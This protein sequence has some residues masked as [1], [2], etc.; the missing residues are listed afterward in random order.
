V[1][2]AEGIPIEGMYVDRNGDGEVT[3]EDR[4][5]YKDAN[6]EFYFGISS[7]LSYKNWELFFSGRANFGNYMYNNVSSENGVYQRLYRAEGPYLSNVT[8][9]VT[10][11]GFVAPQ[12]L[13]D[14]FIQ[15][16][17]FFKMDVI[18]LSY[19]LEDL[20]N[21]KLDLRIS[22]TVN[23]AFTITNYSGIDPE[24]NSGID[25]RIYPRPRV[26]ALGINLAF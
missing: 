12:Y 13:S 25:N 19:L 20:I 26:Y 8:S 5:H 2:D 22:A 21:K 3:D 24:I 14:Y 15:E 9:D 18:S 4:Y 17:S 6:P 10:E 23:N 16:A 1:Y 7:S 11:I